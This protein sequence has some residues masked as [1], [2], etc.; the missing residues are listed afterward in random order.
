[1]R[2]LALCCLFLV[3]CGSLPP[4]ARVANRG[5]CAWRVCITTEDGPA[6]RDYQITN[7]EPVPVTVALTFRTVDNLDR[8]EGGRVE[9]VIRPASGDTIRIRRVRPGPMSADLAV[10]IDLGSRGT[11]EMTTLPA[12]LMPDLIQK[13]LSP[14]QLGKGPVES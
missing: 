14:K 13:L 12:I 7:E 5:S 2:V 6:G 8:P 9:R 4:S 1:M 3:G 10:S 11:L